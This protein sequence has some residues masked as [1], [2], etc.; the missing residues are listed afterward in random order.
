MAARS[1]VPI[2]SVLGIVPSMKM[3]IIQ[4]REPDLAYR[5][6]RASARRKATLET[7]S[8]AMKR[9]FMA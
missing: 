6:Q 4:S 2:T 5:A 9:K 8:A 3:V 7:A 1:G